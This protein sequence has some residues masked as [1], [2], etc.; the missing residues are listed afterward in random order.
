V[1]ISL[2]TKNG[3]VLRSWVLDRAFPVRWNGPTLAVSSKDIA[4]E[5]L[6]IAHHGFKPTTH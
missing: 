3:D 6:E 2:V 4:T 1:Q 5:E